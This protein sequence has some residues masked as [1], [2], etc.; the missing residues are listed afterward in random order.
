[1]SIGSM[2]FVEEKVKVLIIIRVTIKFFRIFNVWIGE[3]TVIYIKDKGVCVV[4]SY[5]IW[6]V[7]Y[8]LGDCG[9]GRSGE[10]KCLNLKIS[11]CMRRW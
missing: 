10:G 1:M 3:G 2:G 9:V 5:V 8:S 7:E 6:I 11:F 4:G